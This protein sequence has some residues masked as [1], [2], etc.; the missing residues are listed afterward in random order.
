M[1]Q[2]PNPTD[3]PHLEAFIDWLYEHVEEL[4]SDAEALKAR[5]LDCKA[6]PINNLLVTRTMKSKLY[7]L[8]LANKV[9]AE[10][11]KRDMKRRQKQTPGS[12]IEMD[13]RPR[14]GDVWEG[15]RP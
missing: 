1:N 6:K 3:Y 4:P 10:G 8:I 15:G 2:D 13:P 7:K 12:S 5:F 11:S 14:L 9:V